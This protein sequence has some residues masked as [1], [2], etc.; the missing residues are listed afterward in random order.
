MGNVAK[1]LNPKPKKT[2]IGLE[3][4]TQDPG[5][6]K[7]AGK[8]KDYIKHKGVPVFAARFCRAVTGLLEVCSLPHL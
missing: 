3:P 6:S 7:G 8:H 5:F 4:K 2:S 1:P